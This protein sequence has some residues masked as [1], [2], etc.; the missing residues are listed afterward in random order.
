MLQQWWKQLRSRDRAR[1][2]VRSQIASGDWPEVV[3][4]IERLHAAG[5]SPVEAESRVVHTLEA[6]I[7]RMMHERRAFDRVAYVQDLDGLS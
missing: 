3:A 2:L 4:A 7:A 1:G 6:E 5:Y